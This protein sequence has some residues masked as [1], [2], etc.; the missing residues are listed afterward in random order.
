MNADKIRKRLVGG[1]RPF[2]VRTSDGRE[3]KVP[4][5]EFLMVTPRGDVV[6]V[7]E[8]GDANVLDALHIV[9]V[10]ELKASKTNGHTKT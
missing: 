8:D 6:V 3:F 2:I 10:K 7:D 9:S 1:F 4:H 5:P